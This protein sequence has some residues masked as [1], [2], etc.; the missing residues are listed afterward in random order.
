MSVGHLCRV[1]REESGAT[2]HDHREKLRFAAALDAF[3]Q[4]QRDLSELALDLG[5]SSHAHFTANFT[6]SLGLAPSRLRA[7]IR[8]GVLA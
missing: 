8:E 3:E 1:F 6:Q 5:Y 4:G 7:A 2:I